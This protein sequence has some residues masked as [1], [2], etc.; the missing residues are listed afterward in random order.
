MVQTLPPSNSMTT[1]RQAE[2]ETIIPDQNQPVWAVQQYNTPH[3]FLFL[4]PILL[5]VLSFIYHL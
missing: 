4:N 5:S 2:A 1:P 3:Q